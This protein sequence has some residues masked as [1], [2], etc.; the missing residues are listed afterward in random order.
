MEANQPDNWLLWIPS[1]RCSCA[2]IYTGE[3]IFHQL[4]SQQ[5]NHYLTFWFQRAYVYEC[6][7]EGKS[8]SGE[9]IAFICFQIND[10]VINNPILIFAEISSDLQSTCEMRPGWAYMLAVNLTG[11]DS[12]RLPKWG[13]V[14]VPHH[15]A[16]RIYSRPN[17]F[18]L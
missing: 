1:S 5:L 8:C 3:F 16:C 6:V 13:Y 14:S 7:N 15:C 11:P 17:P 10:F 2:G 4:S 12:N 18:T 9:S